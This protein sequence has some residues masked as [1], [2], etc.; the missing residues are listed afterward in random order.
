[1]NLLVAVRISAFLREWFTS[2]FLLSQQPGVFPMPA[3]VMFLTLS[4][5]H[6]LRFLTSDNQNMNFGLRTSGSKEKLGLG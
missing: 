3:V 2:E 1:V 5:R 6:A 4:C